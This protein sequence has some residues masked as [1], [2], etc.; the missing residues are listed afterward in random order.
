MDSDKTILITGAAKGIG[1][2]LVNT[3]LERGYNVVAVSRQISVGRPFVASDKLALVE[4]DVG[5]AATARRSAE[6]ARE[7]FGSIDAL[8]NN[9]GIYFTKPFLDYTI[10][11]FRKLSATNVDGFLLMSQAAVKQMIGQKS[12]GSI[13]SI[14]ASLADHPIARVN[15]SVAMITKGGINSATRNL[16]IEFAREKIRF[17]AVAPGTVDTSMHDGASTADVEMRS[18]M[19]TVSK[20]QEIVDAVVYLTEAPNVTGEVLHVDGGAHVGK[21]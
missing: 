14:S 7:R 11:D 18:P 12:G 13:V 1:A 21:W 20:I 17:N 8:V 4:G 2:G 3:F 15:A 5:D 6:T 16:A 19:G 9:A 10:D